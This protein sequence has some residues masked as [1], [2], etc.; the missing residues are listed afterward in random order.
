L[1]HTITTALVHE[2]PLPGKLNGEAD[3]LQLAESRHSW[4]QTSREYSACITPTPVSNFPRDV[5]YNSA[6][7][8]GGTMCIA[9]EYG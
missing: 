3:S 6:T 7:Y 2:W 9:S 4:S 5:H 8:R 1:G